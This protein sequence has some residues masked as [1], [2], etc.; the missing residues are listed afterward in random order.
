M[1]PQAPDIVPTAAETAER[2]EA[3]APEIITPE[4]IAAGVSAYCCAD[5]AFL[6]DDMVVLQIY[7]AMRAMAE[8]QN[9]AL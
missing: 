4:M 7:R 1:T 2:G 6:T 8:E 9:L 5:P 3:G